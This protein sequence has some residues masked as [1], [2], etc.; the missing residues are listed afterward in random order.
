MTNARE[1]KGYVLTGQLH[2]IRRGKSIRF[3][4]APAERPK[5]VARPAKVA[6]MLALAH[7]VQR[8]IDHGVA[9]D[10]AD[11]AR[12]LGLTRARVTQFL[13]LLLLAPDIQESILFLTAV[14]TEPATEKSIR[15][16]ASRADWEAQRKAADFLV[17][18]PAC[19][20]TRLVSD[21]GPDGNQAKDTLRLRH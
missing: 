19:Q 18:S 12:R 7:H 21:N 11:V 14:S 2:R 5:G 1:P 10:R 17:G 20:G 8:A 4:T 15:A 9:R 3:V 16:I 6:R 13:D